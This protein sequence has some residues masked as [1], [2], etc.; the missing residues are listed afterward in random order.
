MDLTRRIY[1]REFKVSVMRAMDGGESGGRVARR[2][3]VS[4][5]LIE[6]WRA[7]WRARG[8]ASFPGSGVRALPKMAP[9]ERTVAELERKIG[10]LTMENDFLK[11][12]LQDCREHPPGVV[13]SG[14]PACG[15]GSGKPAK[16]VGK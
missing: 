16:A 6:R 12:V 5:K 11:K 13:L 7:E 15:N 3:Q 4:P 1:S 9:G 14:A 10:Q 2:M 8:E